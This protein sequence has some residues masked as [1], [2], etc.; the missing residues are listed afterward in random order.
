MQ[1][2]LILGK[3][4]L[5]EDLSSLPEELWAL[6]VGLGGEIGLQG[7]GANSSLLRYEYD[8]FVTLDERGD[9]AE[10]QNKIPE[11]FDKGLDA[12]GV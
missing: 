3:F 9:I 11:L 1:R 2:T 12:Q 5:W 10:V 7:T 4:I 6:P 8:I